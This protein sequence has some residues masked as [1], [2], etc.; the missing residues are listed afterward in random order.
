[1]KA[2]R[3]ARPSDPPI[4]S[5]GFPRKKRKCKGEAG[6]GDRPLLVIGRGA[7]GL[8]GRN[9]PNHPSQTDYRKAPQ[10]RHSSNAVIY[11]G[12][13]GQRIT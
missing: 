11:S 6:R 1:M 9:G 7:A 13:Q 5:W 2:P 8:I 12:K 4:P 3:Y 10:W